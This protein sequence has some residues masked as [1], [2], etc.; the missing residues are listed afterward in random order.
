LPP[1]SRLKIPIG[2]SSSSNE[3]DTIAAWLSIARGRGGRKRVVKVESVNIGREEAIPGHARMGSTGI[4][5][6]PVTGPVRVTTHGLEGDYVHDKKHHGGPD[7]AVYVYLSEDYAWWSKQLGQEIAPGTFG[8]NVTIS[9]LVSAD[10]AIGDRLSIGEAVLEITAPRIPCNTLAARMD[11][12]QFVK[13]YRDGER[14]GA[15]CRVI[16]AGEFAAGTPVTH[17]PY[18][19]RRVGLAEMFRD[20]F[21]RKTLDEPRL[22][23]TLQAPIAARARKDWEELLAAAE[24][25]G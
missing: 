23:E 25:R 6:R 14:P 8:D 17:Q 18:A 19:G 1:K 12:P 2:Q 16:H 15:Y 10:L 5:K 20:W 22:R 3:V 24:A 13:L 9:G 11:D 4:F 21:V 7:Q